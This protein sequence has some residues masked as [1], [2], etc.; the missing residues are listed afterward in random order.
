MVI[1]HNQQKKDGDEDIF[2]FLSLFLSIN[3]IKSNAQFTACLQ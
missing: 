2:I 1:S 3:I